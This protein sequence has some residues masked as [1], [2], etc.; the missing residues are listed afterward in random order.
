MTACSS[1][2]RKG[3]RDEKVRDNTGDGEKD[4]D[5]DEDGRGEGGR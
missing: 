3:A 2:K 4:G 1:M 5:G